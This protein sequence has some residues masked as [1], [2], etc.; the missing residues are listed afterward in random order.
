[1]LFCF[2]VVLYKYLV[3]VNNIG[4]FYG[5]LIYKDILLMLYV[6]LKFREM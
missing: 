4:S 6:I 2:I 1:M 5:I 3:Y